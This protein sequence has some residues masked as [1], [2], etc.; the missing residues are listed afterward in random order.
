LAGAEGADRTRQPTGGPQGRMPVGA[1]HE[2]PEPNRRVRR[3]AVPP[4]RRRK[5]G[6]GG[7]RIT[8]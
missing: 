1:V 6:R 2:P 4:S 7:A 8:V 3:V 5:R